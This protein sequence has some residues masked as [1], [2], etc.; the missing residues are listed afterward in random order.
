M[1]TVNPISSGSRR[2]WKCALTSSGVA[3][4]G[5]GGMLRQRIPQST[6]TANRKTGPVHARIF[7]V[8]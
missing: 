2:S 8:V 7:H 6:K 4:G 1:Q 5:N 3:L